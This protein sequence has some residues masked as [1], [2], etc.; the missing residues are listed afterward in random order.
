MASSRLCDYVDRVDSHMYT[1]CLIRHCH[2]FS[3]LLPAVPLLNPLSVMEEEDLSSY[4]EVESVLDQRVIGQKVEYL[5][6]W[7]NYDDRCF[8]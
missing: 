6:K 3:Y 7:K 4:Y 1:L 2:A 5:I 8:F